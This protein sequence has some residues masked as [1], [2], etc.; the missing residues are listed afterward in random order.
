MVIV[1][2]TVLLQVLASVTFY[3]LIDREAVRED[4]ARRI[5]ELLVVGT[6][7]HSLDSNPQGNDLAQVMSTTYLDARITDVAPQRPSMS[8]GGAMAIRRY[9][10]SWEPELARHELIVW[11]LRSRSGAQDLVGAMQLADGRWL[12]F[13]SHDFAPT[14]PLALRLTVMTLLF[15]AAGLF[16]ALYLLRQQGEPLRHLAQAAHRIGEGR[17]PEPVAIEGS[18]DLRD[19]GF[20]FNEMQRRITG[21][22]EDQARAMEAVSHDFRTPLARLSLASEFIEDEDAKTILTDNV[23]ELDTMLNS[24]RDYL[25]AQH[26]PS[27]PEPVDLA[28][29][30]RQVITPWPG[31][32]RYEGPENLAATTHRGALTQALIQ[33]ADNAVRHGGGGE[34][35]LTTDSA[36]P[37]IVVRDHG[38]GMTAEGISHIYDPFFRADAARQR[39]TAG[40]GLGIPTA[41]R[42]LKRF[43][44]SMD[45]SNHPE[46]G[47]LVTV[48]PP[49]AT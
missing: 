12:S 19:L 11:T 4:H 43:G 40:F 48:R 9:M 35:T 25:R 26:Q 5:A 38:R 31:A 8:D 49:A 46:G 34:I 20:A 10:V 29:L 24:L 21:I 41:A 6:R 15:S 14:W 30:L 33:I 13:R 16:V 1:G 45:V 37:L 32:L 28:A 7:V 47:L 44:G 27:E 42:L 18:A 17:R 22:L 2:A 3:Q 36:G 39:N 23:A